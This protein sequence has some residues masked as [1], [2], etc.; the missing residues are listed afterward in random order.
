[1]GQ[2]RTAVHAHATAGASPGDILTRTNRLLTDLDP[3]L[4]TSCL[5]AKLDLARHRA[6]LATGGHPPPLLRHPDRRTEVLDV[7]PGLLLG[8]DE[9]AE[10]STT[11][12]A[13]PPG[14]VLALYTD[15]LVEV[16]GADIT[17]TTDGLAR[18][19][20]DCEDPHL[21][22]ITDCL[23]HHADGSAARTDDVALI[24]VRPHL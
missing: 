17:D 14:A 8:I 2:V 24:V 1:M 16:P 19:L 13:L 15:G 20:A 12:I 22:D 7:P 18:R 3:G 11:E 5:I 6:H 23:V 9:N 10:Y 21:D 4:F